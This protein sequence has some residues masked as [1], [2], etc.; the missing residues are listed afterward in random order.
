MNREDAHEDDEALF[1]ERA[2]VQ[3]EI[4]STR[5]L[6]PAL[7]CASFRVYISVAFLVVTIFL[8][9][10][11]LGNCKNWA[12][13]PFTTRSDFMIYRYFVLSRAIL[14]LNDLPESIS[15]CC[16]G[17]NK[18]SGMKFYSLVSYS[19]TVIVLTKFEKYL[20]LATVEFVIKVF[21]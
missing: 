14:Y 16:F 4:S 8:L 2:R 12:A 11:K 7:P 3:L 19:T 10:G 9:E 15:V 6:T 17:S 21:H 5:P 20:E 1:S 13:R 18:V